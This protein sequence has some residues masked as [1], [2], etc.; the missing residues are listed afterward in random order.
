MYPAGGT[1]LPQFKAI[2][3]V[4]L[5]LRSGIVAALAGCASQR[6]HNT[7]FFAFSHDFLR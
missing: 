3:I 7:I 1:E 6:Y 2:W 4:F 5:V